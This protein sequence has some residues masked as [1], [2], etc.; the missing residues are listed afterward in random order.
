MIYLIPNFLL[1]IIESDN[2]HFIKDILKKWKE[3][4]GLY[5]YELSS[6]NGNFIKRLLNSLKNLIL[7]KN[8]IDN[9]NYQFVFFEWGSTLLR[10]VTNL[11]KIEKPVVARIHRYEVFE[12]RIYKI[13]F[14]EINKII[15]VSEYIKKVFLK[16]FPNLEGKIVLIPNAINLDKFYPDPDKK[17]NFK[18]CTLSFLEERKRIDLVIEA[19]KFIKNPTIKLHIG[20][21]GNIGTQLK[22]RIQYEKLEDRVF[23]DGKIDNLQEWYRD[24]DIIINSSENE[25]FGVSIIEAM[26]CEVIPFIRGWGA[27]KYLYPKEFI[28]PYHEQKFIKSL[29]GQMDNFYQL[30]DVIQDSERK[31]ARNFVLKNYSLEKQVQNFNS[32]FH[33]L[34]KSKKHENINY[35][36]SVG[37]KW[38][39]KFFLSFI[40]EVKK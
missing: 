20:G 36:K 31:L 26:A 7:I 15:L 37:I 27:A 13:N 39:F 33:S 1:L 34:L 32:L 21:V 19:M 23:L 10:R 2:D 29:S 25:S 9:A 38:I 35:R 3:G 11:F 17:K 18:I 4:K 24:K 30:S 8:L 16:K 5:R 40:K 22:N 28:L 6:G 12:K 14:N